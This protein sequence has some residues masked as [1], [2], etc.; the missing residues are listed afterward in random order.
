[1]LQRVTLLISTKTFLLNLRSKKGWKI[2]LGEFQIDK[3]YSPNKSENPENHK[4]II[5]TVVTFTNWH[6]Y[7]WRVFVEDILN[8][9]RHYKLAFITFL[10]FRMSQKQEFLG[11]WWCGKETHFCFLYIASCAQRHAEFKTLL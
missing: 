3:K 8:I 10:S 9:W 7:S 4:E 6:A 1:M 5:I 2:K 11:S